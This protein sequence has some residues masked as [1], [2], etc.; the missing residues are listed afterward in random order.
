MEILVLAVLANGIAQTI[1]IN[2]IIK[3]IKKQPEEETWIDNIP[4]EEPSPQPQDILE[5][6][7]F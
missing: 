5:Q 6:P 7:L 2:K 3:E 4:E 1:L